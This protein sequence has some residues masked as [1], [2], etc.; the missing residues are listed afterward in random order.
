MTCQRWN[1]RRCLYRPA[2]ETIRPRD[3]EVAA[4]AEASA[5]S[6]V[7]EHHYSGAYPAA[8]FRFGMHRGGDLVGVAVFSVPAQPRAL[9]CLP[10][11]VALNVE[12]GRLV[13]LDEVPANG[14]SWLIARCFELLRRQGI[15]GVVAFSDPM[16]RST[17]EGAIVMPGHVGTIYQATNACYLGRS[18]PD[19]HRLLPDGTVFHRRAQAKIRTHETGWR[20]ASAQL[21]HFGAAPLHAD[22]DG[23]EWLRRWLPLISRPLRHPGN[24]KYAWTM[25]RTDRRH[26]PISLPY[27]KIEMKT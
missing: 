22:E 21:E 19:T 7:L 1:S 25:R 16:P 12:L 6:F 17:S 5:K 13:L 14:E 20:Y 18:K 9:A 8:R 26:L 2:G 24:H 23:A 15:S 4:I 11:P 10:G 27:P 3:Y